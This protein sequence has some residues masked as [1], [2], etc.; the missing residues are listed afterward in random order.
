M[1]MAQIAVRPE[2]LNAMAQAIRAH[3]NRISAAIQAIDAE[4]QRIGAGSF[5]GQSADALRARYSAM[6]QRLLVFAPMLNKFANQ[7]DEAA[8]VFRKAD[9]SATRGA[10]AGAGGSGANWHMSDSPAGATSTGG[11]LGSADHV[12]AIQEANKAVN[13]KLW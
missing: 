10:G 13:W 5:A 1:L 4:M 6:Q 11:G 8:A 3:S 9:L 7:L 12:R 2:Q